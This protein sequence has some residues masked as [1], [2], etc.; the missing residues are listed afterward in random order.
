[1]GEFENI[2]Q[3]LEEYAEKEGKGI[4]KIAN[5]SSNLNWMRIKRQIKE[6]SRY[7]PKNA[8]VLDLGCGRGHNTLMLKLIRPD[9]KIIGLSPSSSSQWK[10]YNRKDCIFHIGDDASSLDRASFAKRTGEQFK[11]AGRGTARRRTDAGE[12]DCF[13]KD[14]EAN[15]QGRCGFY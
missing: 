5:V 8:R 3:I 10:L 2:R 11:Q 4:Y 14:S 12:A 15:P 1:M 7:I 6:V 13:F 9:I